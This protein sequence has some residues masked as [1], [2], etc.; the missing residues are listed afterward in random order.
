MKVVTA[1]D[2]EV[3]K[4]MPGTSPSLPGPPDMR[5]DESRARMAPPT[6]EQL[7]AMKGLCTGSNSIVPEVGR[8]P[9]INEDG[10]I[11]GT[12][13]DGVPV[14]DNEGRTGPATQATD[15]NGPAPGHR[16]A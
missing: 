5:D 11:V 13:I 14:D 3:T 2:A 10:N 1:H 12:S 7:K 4:G 16:A 9:I 8:E 15:H 6:D